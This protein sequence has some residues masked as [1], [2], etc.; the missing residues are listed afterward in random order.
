[1]LINYYLRELLKAIRRVAITK[2]VRIFYQHTTPEQIESD[3]HAAGT[4]G[5]SAICN[6]IENNGDG[7][8]AVVKAICRRWNF[9][10]APAAFVLSVDDCTNIAVECLL[11][12]FSQKIRLTASAGEIVT[13]MCMWIEQKVRRA[14]L[15]EKSHAEGLCIK[16]RDC[17]GDDDRLC[18]KTSY[19]KQY[20]RVFVSGHV[21]E[22][23]SA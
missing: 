9:R 13:G 14:I 21:W 5:H 1:M 3:I 11:T 17:Q 16:K 6:F 4:D 12:N 19:V 7:F 22:R 8:R 18:K 15:K 20:R 23:L 10:S 2:L